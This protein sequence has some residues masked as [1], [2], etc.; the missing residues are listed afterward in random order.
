[1]D[2]GAG[3]DTL[4][5]VAMD[6]SRGMVVQGGA[7]VDTLDLSRITQAV[8]VDLSQIG[9]FQNFG[10]ADGQVIGVPGVIGYLSIGGIEN[11][12]GTGRADRLTGRE[13]ANQLDGGGGNDTLSG[14][15]GN[16]TLI[17]LAG[18]DVLS[19]GEGD[20]VL[21]GGKGNDTLTGGAGADD[22]VF[23]RR[24]GTDRI[25]D[26]EDGVDDIAIAGVTRLGQITFTDV[27]AGVR[28]VANG[29]TVIVEGMTTAELRDADN[30]IF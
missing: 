28:L 21:R 12:M 29:T 6:P 18:A 10:R 22:F 24:D 4:R 25:T 2:L 26:F 3:D 20:D 13:T 27:A 9:T 5:I 7:G 30:F 11:L 19:G 17:G 15:A 1:V 8:S 14:L 23:G 16:D